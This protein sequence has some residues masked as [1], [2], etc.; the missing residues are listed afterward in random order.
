MERIFFIA[1]KYVAIFLAG[2][3]GLLQTVKDFK[4][5]EGKLN[6]FGRI[7][8]VTSAV[9]LVVALI[10]QTIELRMD[11]DE[12]RQRERD[13]AAQ[14][15]LATDTLDTARRDAYGIRQVDVETEVTVTGAPEK[16]SGMR[17]KW[18]AFL[19]RRKPASIP[20]AAPQI[21]TPGEDKEAAF[22]NLW[23]SMLASTRFVQDGP[24]LAASYSRMNDGSLRE[25]LTVGKGSALYPNKTS[26]PDYR[27]LSPLQY[28]LL[29]KSDASAR[30]M[31]VSKLPTEDALSPGWEMVLFLPTN[32]E[33]NA[34]QY[35]FNRSA[36]TVSIHGVYKAA[37]VLDDSGGIETVQ[38]LD[39]KTALVVTPYTA[40]TASITSVTLTVNNN[41]GSFN[42]ARKH[43]Y[44]AKEIENLGLDGRAC[45]LIHPKPADFGYGQTVTASAP[46]T[47]AK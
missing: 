36:G 5:K 10:S 37:T 35:S 42:W 3:F 47:P 32:V 2:G 9:A 33:T 40:G 44:L 28:L 38:D 34:A 15:K 23:K 46:A 21:S 18:S 1:L 19:D 11:L 30:S 22:H 25:S 27:F 43:Q 31:K 13:L 45:A 8:V 6:R 26:D 20:P 39:S 29:A 4:D 7:A 41:T 16:W 24:D 17:S 14:M 12:S